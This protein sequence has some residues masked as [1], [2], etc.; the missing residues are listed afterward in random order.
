[1]GK[2]IIARRKEAFPVPYSLCSLLALL[3]RRAQK[4]KTREHLQDLFVIKEFSLHHHMSACLVNERLP[5]A[6]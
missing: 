3:Q 6:P 5:F 1:M 2:A 4:S